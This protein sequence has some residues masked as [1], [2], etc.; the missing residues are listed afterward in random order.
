VGHELSQLKQSRQPQLAWDFVA[1]RDI[2]QGEELL[3]DYGDEWVVSWEKH[4]DA[5]QTKWLEKI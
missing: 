4:V 2:D 1:L 5:W 3:L